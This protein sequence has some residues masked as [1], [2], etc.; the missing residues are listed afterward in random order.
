MAV[1]V[2]VRPAARP[3]LPIEPSAA[4][5]GAGS[6]AEGWARPS[7]ALR[8]LGPGVG[9]MLCV[10]G[11]G[12]AEGGGARFLCAIHIAPAFPSRMHAYPGNGVV[13]PYLNYL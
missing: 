4:G 13:S 2:R 9:E 11:E 6:T 7:P 8:G 10:R 5:S 12:A 3:A 1:R